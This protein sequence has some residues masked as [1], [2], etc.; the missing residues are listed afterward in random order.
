MNLNYAIFI[1]EPI[2]TIPDLVHDE[3]EINPKNRRMTINAS[4]YKTLDTLLKS[5]FFS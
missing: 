3:I 1:S 5:I 4:E 2:M